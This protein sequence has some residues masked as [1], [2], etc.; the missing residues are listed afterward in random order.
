MLRDPARRPLAGAAREGFDV[1]FYDQRGAGFSSR[2]DL[3][4][5]APY[6]VAGHVSDLEQIRVRMGADRMVLAGHG[7]GAS[8]AVAYALEHRDRV[9]AMMLLSP[10]PLWYPAWEEFVSP[11]ARARLSDIQASTMALLQR[12]TPRLLIGRLTASTSRAAAHGLVQDWEAD[13]WWT[14]MTQESWR[15]GQPKHTCSEPPTVRVPQPEG[16]GFFAHSYTLSDALRAPDRRRELGA[17]AVPVLILR[18]LCDWVTPGVAGEYLEHLPGAIY[19]PVPGAGHLLW[20]D[21]VSLQEQVV[22]DF[23]AGRPVPMAL[24]TPRR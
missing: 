23:L 21:M 3:R 18:G 13:Q 10:N 2:L 8:L 17:L 22:A 14:R 15:L 1:V 24:F 16:L 6:T 9:E 12:P 7:W 11:S 4:R 19:V 5:E 20:L